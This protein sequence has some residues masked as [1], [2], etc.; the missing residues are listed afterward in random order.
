MEHQVQDRSP[1]N[2]GSVV[3]SSSS[4]MEPMEVEFPDNTSSTFPPSSDRINLLRNERNESD[5]DDLIFGLEDEHYYN[6]KCATK[7]RPLYV[8]FA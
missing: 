8:G 7:C 3:T 6:G 1:D 4:K 2:G 5:T